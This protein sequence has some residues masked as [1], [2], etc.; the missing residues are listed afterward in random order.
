MTGIAM[1]RVLLALGCGVALL[2]S[3][4][5][6]STIASSLVPSR[7]IWAEQVAASYGFPLIP[8]GQGGFGYARGG[9]R[10]P[11]LALQIDAFIANNSFGENDVVLVS[12]GVEE[13]AAQLA[14]YLSGHLSYQQLL[15]DVNQ[16]GKDYGAQVQRLVNLGAKHI[17]VTGTYG[18]GMSPYAR[19]TNQVGLMDQLSYKGDTCTGCPR[20]FNESFLIAIN[21]LGDNVLYVDAAN[22]F[23]QVYS[24]PSNYLGSNA[25]AQDVAC[26]TALVVNCTPGTIVPG[27]NYDQYLFAGEVYMTPAANRLGGVQTYNKI[28][29]RW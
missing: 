23:N 18:L 8:A 21:Q 6:G 11:D 5:G 2:L 29:G 9:T 16:A 13:I 27:A 10:I 17:V 15:I 19:A 14:L 12:A 4:C 28:K 1:R 25:N 7:N 22:Y 3:S 24:N 20:S 26:T